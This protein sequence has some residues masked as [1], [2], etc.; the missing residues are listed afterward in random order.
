MVRFLKIIFCLL[1]SFLFLK[2]SFSQSITF[3]KNYS[4]DG[5]TSGNCV[6]QTFDRG[7]IITGMAY[8]IVTAQDVVLMKTDSLGN[9]TW[10][11]IYGGINTDAG[12][13]VEQTPDSGYI[14][15]AEKDLIST[16]NS[17]IWLL[18]TDANG[19][20]LW[21][22]TISAGAGAN[23][24]SCI[25]QTYDGGFVITGY[26]SARGAGS[27][28]V[29]LV[30]TNSVG[31]TLWTRTFGGA[32]ADVGYCVQQT[33]D[34]GFVIAGS[35]Q[36]NFYSDV[37]L[38]K[39][40]KSGDSLWT[41]T[42]DKGQSDLAYTVQETN[43][44]DYVLAGYTWNVS[45]SNYDMY[46]IKTN[47]SGDTLWTKI[48]GDSTENGAYCLEITSD[49]GII[50][51][52]TTH[53]SGSGNVYDVFLV[54]T[55]SLG[56]TLWTKKYGGEKPDQG[57]FVRQTSDGGYIIVGSTACFDTIPGYNIYLVKT[58]SVGGV[59]IGINDPE[60]I[61]VGGILLYP[62]PFSFTA[63]VE[64]PM[65][66]KGSNNLFYEIDDVLGRLLV[67]KRIDQNQNTFTIEKNNLISG[68]YLLKII[69][70][71]KIIYNIKFIIQ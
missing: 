19:D 12:F 61:K 54:R 42:Y 8:S 34:S 27:Y 52:G 11:K 57:Y 24:P 68:I 22:K 59:V 41:R 18:K 44:G 2:N 63:T 35:Y 1:S 4:S 69:A 30:K 62:N 3:E 9:L 53:V 31:D 58:D 49:G 40:D 70:D 32:D 16:T 67:M 7:Y 43:T 5:A 28:D 6:Q 21:T 20:T 38:I 64:F 65:Q 55:D 47:H 39:T 71:K 10:T 17:T 23:V 15:V 37:Y 29:L 26:T 36:P 13:Y 51:A 14:V 48:I 66:N 33:S 60:N 46:L 56:D 50:I 45:M 25:R